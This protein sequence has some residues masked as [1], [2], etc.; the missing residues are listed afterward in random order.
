MSDT[1]QIQATKYA[2]FAG[3]EVF[4]IIPN[5]DGTVQQLNYEN[6]ATAVADATQITFTVGMGN[7]N[8]GISRTM[9]NDI[10][11][12]DYNANL[13][14]VLNP[15]SNLNAIVNN[16]GTGV[17]LS[18]TN[19]SNPLL[20]SVLVIRKVGSAPSSSTDGVTVYS[21][22]GQSVA[23]TVTANTVYYY[24]AYSMDGSG[25]LS[26]PMIIQVNTGLVSV[27]GTIT[28][29]SGGGLSNATLQLLD[30]NNNFIGVTTSA[31]DGTYA[32]SNIANGSYTLTASHPTAVINNP[33]SVA[34][35]IS[36]SSQ[37]ED[38]SATNQETLF[39]LFNSSSVTVG[40]TVSIPWAYRNI[41]NNE[42]VNINLL[43][44]GMLETIASG[45]PILNGMI[46]WTVTGPDVSSATLEISLADDPTVN[47]QYTLSIAPSYDFMGTPTSGPS[48]LAVMFVDES[49]S[50]TAWLWDFETV[51]QARCRILC[52]CIRILVHIPYLKQSQ[53]RAVR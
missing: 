38:F 35:T 26:T 50:A 34:I 15:P 32:I 9:A 52:T 20:A 24:A 47:A 37:E 44:N 14:T 25:N 2:G 13:P 7:A 49:S 3:L 31:P 17:A 41:G 45:V 10:Y 27:Y 4:V 33:S 8:T 5:T 28:L 21:G 36:G 40:N 18:W 23:D 39:L 30:N 43:R 6:L 51:P 46:S 42:T 16:A 48:P 11:N 29:T 53:E 1:Y 22:T 19:I 12:P